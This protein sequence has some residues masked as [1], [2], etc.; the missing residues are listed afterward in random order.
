MVFVLRLGQA[1]ERIDLTSEKET[2]YRNAEN[3]IFNLVTVISLEFIA[4][5]LV[6]VGL[7]LIRVVMRQYHLKYSDREPQMLMSLSSDMF[8]V[9]M[10]FYYALRMPLILGILSNLSAMIE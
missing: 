1:Q 10:P 7:M 9:I 8:L 6:S 5:S 4:M 3:L 2:K